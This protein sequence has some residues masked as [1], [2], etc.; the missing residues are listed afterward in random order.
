MERVGSSK[1]VGAGVWCPRND[2]D[3]KRNVCELSVLAHTFSIQEGADQLCTNQAREDIY[4][5]WCIQTHADARLRNVWM[6]DTFAYAL[7]GLMHS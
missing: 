6:L 5:K 1:L 2:K 7:A 3:L 4:I